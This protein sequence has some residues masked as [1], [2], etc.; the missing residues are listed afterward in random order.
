MNDYE[1]QLIQAVVDGNLKLARTLSGIILRTSNT[2]KDTEF[3]EKM[4]S[5]LDEISNRKVFE[6]PLNL[7][8]VL[9]VEDSTQFAEGKFLLRPEDANIVDTALSLYRCAEDL[10]QRGIPYAPAV[11]LH[12]QSGC[13]K[14]ALAKYIAH[15][16]E[17][18][19]V[20]VNAA[21][22]MGS[23]L[24][25]SQGNLA[26]AFEFVRSHPCVFC[27]DEIDAFGMARGQKN[28]VGEMNRIVITLMQEMDNLPNDIIVVGTTNRFDRLD[29]ALVRRFPFQFEIHP[30]TGSDARTLAAKFFKFAGYTEEEWKAW[31]QNIPL[32]ET[33][34]AS[35]IVRDCTMAVVQRVVEG[36]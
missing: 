7:E 21:N 35:S 26:R 10:K 18:P 31:I 24:G 12:G 8:S 27:F 33:I 16:A 29:P 22:A 2:K 1:R 20:Y 19:F 36:N 3:C 6:L 13:G 28:D 9:R 23:Y 32:D 4:L 17:L 25:Q 11:M 5:R 34:P 15:K 30:M 14:T